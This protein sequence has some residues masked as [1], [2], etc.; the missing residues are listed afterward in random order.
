M[1]MTEEML[2]IALQKDSRDNISA[3]IVKLPGIQI[4]AAG[5]GVTARRKIK[6]AARAAEAAEVERTGVS[7]K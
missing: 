6:E 1:L 7:T 4:A 5:G 3:I 2:D